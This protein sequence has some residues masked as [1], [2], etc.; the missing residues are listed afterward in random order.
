MKGKYSFL[1]ILYEYA[2]T[3]QLLER[4][5]FTALIGLMVLLA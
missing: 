3:F 2:F 4:E 1:Q 5:N